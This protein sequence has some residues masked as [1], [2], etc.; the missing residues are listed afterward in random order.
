LELSESDIK[1]IKA[2]AGRIGDYGK[3]TIAASGGVVDIITEDRRR[4]R[5]GYKDSE[6]NAGRNGNV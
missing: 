5:N 1:E 3:I 4:I 2:A 6:K